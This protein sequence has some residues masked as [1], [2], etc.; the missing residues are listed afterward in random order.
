MKNLL[1]PSARTAITFLLTLVIGQL[2]LVRKIVIHI[3]IGFLC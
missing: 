1:D 2:D 3:D